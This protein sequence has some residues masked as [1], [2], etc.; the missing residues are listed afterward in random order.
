MEEVN[1]KTELNGTDKK[2]HISD[3]TGKAKKP[4]ANGQTVN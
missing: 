2:L 4:T 1:K 3:V